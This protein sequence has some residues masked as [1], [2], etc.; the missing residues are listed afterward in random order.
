MEANTRGKTGIEISP[1]ISDAVKKTAELLHAVHLDWFG[2]LVGE[3]VKD[4]TMGISVDGGTEREEP[5]NGTHFVECL[6][7]KHTVALLWRTH[8]LMGG[9]AITPLEVEVTVEPGQ[10]TMMTYTVQQGNTHGLAAASA[11]IKGTRPA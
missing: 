9:R 5:W 4:A 7:G 3:I 2:K 1:G 8:S 10:V 6:P 11:E